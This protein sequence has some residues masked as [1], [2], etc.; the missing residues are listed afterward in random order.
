MPFLGHLSEVEIRRCVAGTV[1][2]EA[3]RHLWL[4]ILCM[5]RLADA[6]Q[7]RFCW[8]RRG[9]LGRLVRIDPAREVDE[10]LAQLA[11]DQQSDAA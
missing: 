1:S 6:G 4:C 10:L 2:V 3:E 9:P 8:E 5:Q 7:H 11:E